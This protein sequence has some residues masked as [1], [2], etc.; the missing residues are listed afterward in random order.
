VERQ[1]AFRRVVQ[2]L[3][4][5]GRVVFVLHELYG[6]PDTEIAEI[7][8]TSILVVRARLFWARRELARR[9]Q[10]EPCLAGLAEMESL[11]LTGH[12]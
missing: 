3:A 7:L 9:L 5:N 6:L 2:E 10:Q 1:R 8:D 11:Q 4:E 12:V